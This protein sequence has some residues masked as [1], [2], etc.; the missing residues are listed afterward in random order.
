M[1]I[2]YLGHDAVYRRLRTEGA[3]GWDRAESDYEAQQ[4]NILKA[5]EAGHAPRGGRLLELGCG[6]GNVSVR[7]AA[8][9]YDVTGVDIAPA[10]VA[11]ANDRWQ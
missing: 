1:K 3:A 8:L 2:D 4:A 11:W 6:A 9:G 10:A 7:M 5:L